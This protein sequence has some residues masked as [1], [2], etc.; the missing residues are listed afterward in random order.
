MGSSVE[1]KGKGS[2]G[3]VGRGAYLPWL[4]R[5]PSESVL[6]EVTAGKLGVGSVIPSPLLPPL[7]L[8]FCWRGAGGVRAAR[9]VSFIARAEEAECWPLRGGRGEIV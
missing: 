7:K 4:G 5:E 1:R 8:R 9:T 6:W 2:C 3:L